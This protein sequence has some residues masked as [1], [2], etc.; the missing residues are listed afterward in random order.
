MFLLPPVQTR[1]RR[2]PVRRVGDDDQRHFRPGFRRGGAGARRRYTRPFAL[3]PAEVRGP[4][5]VAK[6]GRLI[7]RRELQQVVQR[8]G[9]QIHVRVRIAHGRET[10][11]Y[12][13]HSEVRRFRI[14]RLVPEKR[15]G[16]ARIGQRPNGISRAGGPILRILVVVEE[17]AVPLFLPPFRAGEGGRAPLHRARKSQSS[18]PHLSESPARVDAHVHVHTA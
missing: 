15:R 14:R 7:L 11:R 3:H 9:E 12:G 10:L 16:Y 4:G 6:P 17:D 1:Q 8:S 18:P 2:L 5:R 13:E